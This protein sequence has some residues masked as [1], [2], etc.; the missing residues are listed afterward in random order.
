MS[1][2]TAGFVFDGQRI[3][4][5][6]PQCESLSRERVRDHLQ[7]LGDLRRFFIARESHDDGNHHLHVYA[8]W[9]KRRRFT[10]SRTF[11]VEGFH[12]NISKPRSA[13][14]VVKYC[15]KEDSTPLCNFDIEELTT[16]GRDAGWRDLLTS[17]G[18]AG[19]FLSGVRER[20]PR[21]YCV[22]NQQLR[23]M[24]ER[25]WAIPDAPYMGRRRH[26]FL[27][28]VELTEWVTANLEVFIYNLISSATAAAS[29]TAYSTNP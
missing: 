18:T 16:S 9:S 19:E 8:D 22:L 10:D 23:S 3:F 26:E 13:R 17:S 4:L 6:Y 20:F 1:P 24:A 2:P 7:D 27:E 12:P 11:D 21:D 14:D 5:T 28:P 29:A 15:A 25:E